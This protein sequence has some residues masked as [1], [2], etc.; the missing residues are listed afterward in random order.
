MGGPSAK[1]DLVA[2]G[3][4]AEIHR[5]AAGGAKDDDEGRAFSQLLLAVMVPAWASTQ[6]SIAMDRPMPRPWALVV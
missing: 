5:A 1:G 6:W 4:G 3:L 2:F